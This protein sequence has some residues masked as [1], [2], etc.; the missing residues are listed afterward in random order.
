[1][2]EKGRCSYF[3]M[4]STDGDMELFLNQKEH[5]NAIS[6][7]GTA[8]LIQLTYAIGFNEATV[9]IP[10]VGLQCKSQLLIAGVFRCQVMEQ[11]K[12]MIKSILTLISS[13][14][15]FII[16]PLILVQWWE[17]SNFGWK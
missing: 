5:F 12:E 6:I 4:I 17:G 9:S 1:M 13:L 15:E 10:V 2:H 3:C 8:L 7:T 11:M 16:Q 14:I